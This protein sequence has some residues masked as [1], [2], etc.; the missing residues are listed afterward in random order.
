MVLA[1]EEGQLN[2]IKFFC[3]N[4]FNLEEPKI[5]GWNALHLAAQRGHLG[6]VK[7]LLESG[8]V[9]ERKTENGETAFYIG[10]IFRFFLMHTILTS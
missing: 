4:Q 3:K 7:Y 1:A 2:A 5:N 10:N 8:V 9:I 6:I